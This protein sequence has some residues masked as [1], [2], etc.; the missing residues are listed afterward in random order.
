MTDAVAMRTIDG[1]DFALEPQVA[2]HAE[3]MFA[4]LGDP[5]I[6]EHENAPPP[7]VEWLRT[8]FRR[9]ESRRSADGGELWL[10]WVI[11]LPDGRLAGYVQA[12][13]RADC[14]AG[15]AYELNSAHWG[16]GLGTRAV[17][18]MIVELSARYGVRGLTAVL[19][20]S[21]ARSLRLLERLGFVPAPDELR[22]EH[23]V[24]PDELLLRRDAAPA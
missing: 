6:Y 14:S 3:P 1:G 21:N 13:V 24:E 22:A 2:A 19:K 8:R 7:S 10:N 4:V 20:R 18:A 16:R 11:R 23:G 5:A 15:I 17:Q 12:T 9:L